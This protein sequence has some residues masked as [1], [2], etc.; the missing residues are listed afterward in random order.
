MKRINVTVDEAL[1]NEVKRATGERTSSGTINKALE[2]FARVNR[3]RKGLAE[4]QKLGD[5][6]FWPGYYESVGYEP[7]AAEKKRVSADERRAPRKA[8]SSR[9]T[10]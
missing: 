7:P 6:A 3:L 9:G 5:D 2:E 10:R 8:G 1:L 4:L